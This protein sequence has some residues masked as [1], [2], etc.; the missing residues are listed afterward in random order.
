MAITTQSGT[1]TT[2]R[3][4]AT[5]RLS[6][7]R[8]LSTRAS[9]RDPPPPGDA[10]A[11]AA[12][13]PPPCHVGMPRWGGS[14][15]LLERADQVKDRGQRADAPDNGPGIEPAR[16]L[17]W[18]DHQLIPRAEVHLIEGEPSPDRV[19]KRPTGPDLHAAAPHEGFGR[20]GVL[21]RPARGHDRIRRQ[22]VGGDLV[23]PGL[24]DGAVDAQADHCPHVDVGIPDVAA[25][26]FR[27]VVLGLG[28]QHALQRDVGDSRERKQPSGAYR[29][30]VADGLL[31]GDGHLDPIPDLQV[32]VREPAPDEIRFP[33]L[34]VAEPTGVAGGSDILVELL[35]ARLELR[36]R[37]LGSPGVLCSERLHREPGRR[38]DEQNAQRP[39]IPADGC[40]RA[41]GRHGV[42]GFLHAGSVHWLS[43]SNTPAYLGTVQT[44]GPSAP[45]VSKPSTIATVVPEQRG[46]GPIPQDR[47]PGVRSG[48]CNGFNALGESPEG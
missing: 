37:G 17:P 28:A 47:P 41:L 39:E 10:G 1:V 18:V 19:L 46:V 12:A 5:T 40:G 38:R 6:A 45:V 2:I 21:Y 35:E 9:G 42:S 43:L 14:S 26:D 31:T 3:T 22:H 34:L 11:A 23:E 20:I 48:N 33:L 24:A 32:P 29:E 36:A 44:L 30:R 13:P 15:D 16:A 27:K 7:R 8:A 25:Q 4:T